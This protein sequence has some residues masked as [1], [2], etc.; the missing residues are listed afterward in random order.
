MRGK[1]YKTYILKNPS[2]ATGSSH[3]ELRW[4]HVFRCVRIELHYSKTLHS[5]I[6]NILFIYIPLG[7]ISGYFNH[8]CSTDVFSQNHGLLNGFYV[9]LN[10]L[11]FSIKP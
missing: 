2:K 9:L 8:C 5:F 6:L 7:S 10:N 11:R 3:L 1:P 4:L